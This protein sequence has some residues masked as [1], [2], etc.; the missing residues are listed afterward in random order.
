MIEQE[1]RDRRYNEYIDA[2]E[3]K[4]VRLDHESYRT[5]SPDREK[6]TVTEFKQKLKE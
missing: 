5:A 4:L 6:L 2:L 1:D 3:D